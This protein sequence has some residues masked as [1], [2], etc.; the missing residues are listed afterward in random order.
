MRREQE[1]NEKRNRRATTQPQTPIA[2][3]DTSTGVID[4]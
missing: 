4:K 3:L 2:Y 1:E